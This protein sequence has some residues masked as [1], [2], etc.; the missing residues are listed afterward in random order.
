MNPSSRSSI[1]KERITSTQNRLSK[2]DAPLKTCLIPTKELEVLCE[3]AVD[4]NNL[5]ANGFQC[6]ARIF[7]QGWSK[8][9]NRL[10]GPIYPELVKDFWVHATVTPSAVISFVLG[11]EV[12]IT[13]KLIRKLYNLDDEEGW[14]ELQ[15]HTVDWVLV[16]KQISTVFGI[17][18]H[19]TGT[20]RPFYK[21]WA[22][23]ILGSLHHRKRML[24]S[25]YIS[26]SH[27]F[28]LPRI[29]KQIEINISHI[30]FE[31]LKT[32]IFDSREDE[33]AKYPH[34][35]RTTIPFGRM[36]SDILIES[37]V[38]DFLRNPNTSHSLEVTH[39]P[40]FNG[41]DLFGLE[42]IKKVPV[43]CTS[44]P[45]IVSRRIAVEG[46]ISLFHKELDRVVKFY[47][48]DCVRKQSDVDPAW[49]RGRVLPSKE[50]ILKKDRKEQQ[51]RL[52]RKAKEDEAE[53]AKKLRVTYDPDKVGS[54]ERRNLRIR[55][56]LHRTRSSFSSRQVYTPPPSVPKPS[57]QSPPSETKANFILPTP[58]PSSFS[59]P[60]LNP[61]PLNTLPPTPS[62]KSPSPI[63]F[64]NS[65]PSPQS[66]PSDTP[67]SSIILLDIPSSS[68]T[69]PPPS[70]SHP[71]PTRISQ[72]YSLLYPDC[73]LSL[74]PPEPEPSTYLELFRY[75][76]INGLDL[77]K[78]AFLS[79]LNDVSTRN[80]W[81]SF[82]KV[83]Q[84]EAV[85]VQRRL[86]AAA[87]RSR[88]MLRNFEEFW[89]T[90]LKGRYLLEEKPFV[91]EI[92]QLRL[93]AAMEANPCR[94]MVIWI[95]KYPVLLG[96]FKTLFDFLRENPS[97][98]DPSL[99][100]PEVVDP[101]EVEGP[102]A[103]RNLAAILQ[104]L[105]N[106]DS[107]IPAAEY[108]DASMQEA[109]SEDHVSESDPVEDIP[110]NDTSMEAADQVVIP[111]D[112]SCEASSDEPSR[113]A[114]TL[115][116]I[117]RRQDE[118]SSRNDKYDAFIERQE[119][120][121]NEMK[122]MLAKILSRLGPS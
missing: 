64:T 108:G 36:I 18:S 80:I 75:E 100:I 47:L 24:S 35:P 89:V 30:L 56:P 76:V 45:D 32:S 72:P 5:K 112:R 78:E 28:R 6:D 84:K 59:S 88:G 57:L 58:S 65:P 79:G 34:I 8:Y 119:G 53:R 33:R 26:P 68:T 61:T 73:K 29:R 122:E 62:D 11:H 14:S 39:G 38:V 109:E 55:D 118:Q 46:F 69:A 2:N 50:D 1:S 111:V 113:L 97:K 27:I 52:K 25:S 43:M 7:E 9:L 21:A 16:Q 60:I 22:E 15:P 51:A 114:R 85:E 48:E 107:E 103:P 19:N 105:E 116:V 20:L 110:A 98:K 70:I 106:G 12:V 115:E 71:L 95:P 87:P 86:V 91:D 77:L 81:K 96:D 54:S 31:N 3:S 67:T 42:V 83:F 44:F 92:E 90:S 99:V 40:I 66:I 82:H 4:I 23:I 101:P 63:P 102:S 94:D 17:D 37:K 93:A 13:E 121:N 104:A 49:I 120:H 41:V 10:V 74:Y 117:Q